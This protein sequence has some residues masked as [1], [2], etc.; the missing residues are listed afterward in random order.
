MGIRPKCKFLPWDFS[1]MIRTCRHVALFV[2]ALIMLSG[3][4]VGQGTLRGVVHDST[5]A[6]IA[7][8][9]VTVQSPEGEQTRDTGVDGKFLFEHTPRAVTLQVQANGF[10]PYSQPLTVSAVSEINVVLLP[11]NRRENATVTATRTPLPSTETGAAVDVVTEQ[12]L[13]SSGGAMLSDR[14]RQVVGFSTFRRSSSVAINPTSEGVSLR[15]VGSSGAS[16]ALV[17][18]DGVPIS[19][20]FGGWIYWDQIPEIAVGSVEVLRGGASGL[21]GSD[22]MGGVVNILSRPPE[23]F[24]LDLEGSLGNAFVRSGQAYATGSLRQWHASASGQTLATDGYYIVPDSIRGTVDTRSTIDFRTGM[25]TLERDISKGRMFA[26]GALLAESRNNGTHLQV[27]DTHLGRLVAGA[28][29]APENIGNINLRVF[30]AGETFHQTFS[31]ISTDRSTEVLTRLQDS[32]SDEL[33]TSAQWTRVFGKHSLVAGFDFMNRNGHTAETLISSGI[34]TSVVD[35]GGRTRNY[36]Y[37][38]EDVL[39][40]GRKLILTAA[41]RGDTW[42]NGDGH[43]NT[44]PLVK[45]SKPSSAVFPERTESAFSPR[46]S[47]L[48]SLRGGVALTAAFYRAFRAPTLN[49]LYRGFR[50]GNVVTVA[51]AAL[52]AEQL[53]GGEAGVRAN[54]AGVVTRA[55]FF[56]NSISDPVANVTLSTTP[57]VITRQRQNLGSTRALGVELEAEWKVSH[58][59]LSGGYQ[60]TSATVTDFSANPALVG[61]WVP[62]V[63]QQQF[64]MQA[65][66]TASR[67]TLAVQARAAGTQYDDDQ[68]LLPL[69]P[70]F[71]LDVFVSRGISRQ[72]EVFFAGENVTGQRAIVGRT[73]YTTIG[74]PALL[75]G[76][77][78]LHFGRG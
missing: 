18:L 59:V 14:L 4:A 47:A 6:V 76:G 70:F 78:R 43:S 36:G 30:G 49:E 11:Q 34:A 61:N 19:D 27:N 62:Q 37:F 60:F 3:I 25:G 33:G 52:V 65:R 58:L 15:G 7:G 67:W 29:F 32:P 63:P 26:T 66:Y 28:D 56:A 75:R 31:A 17:M 45:T 10:E 13:Q 50:M 46:L 69:D 64:T 72:V 51:N 21:Y 54:I 5:D 57:T 8:A 38:G 48:Y 9:H 73:P 16:R 39:P 41:L 23:G 22:A 71:S 20:P 35:S 42:N 2:C 55:V 74:P 40:L 12:A 1:C 77:V 24:G 68:N 44:T 53:T